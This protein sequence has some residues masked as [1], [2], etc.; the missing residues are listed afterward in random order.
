MPSSCRVDPREHLLGLRWLIFDEGKRLIKVRTAERAQ[1]VPG[2]DEAASY[3]ELSR[4]RRLPMVRTGRCVA[5]QRSTWVTELTPDE[6]S[7]E[8]LVEP[9][10][11]SISAL[12]KKISSLSV[13]RLR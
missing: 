12:S 11:M 1:Y 7:S 3:W 2:G 9:S 10:R 13:S 8:L 5:L 4:L 6:I